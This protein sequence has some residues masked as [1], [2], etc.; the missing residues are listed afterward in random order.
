MEEASTVYLELV[1]SFVS[2]HKQKGNFKYSWLA[3]LIDTYFPGSVFV[4]VKYERHSSS[5]TSNKDKLLN[6]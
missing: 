3:Y 2:C 5:A 1:I 4:F 6:K